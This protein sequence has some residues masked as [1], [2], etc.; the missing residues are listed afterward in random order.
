MKT[1]HTVQFALFN[2][3]VAVICAVCASVYANMITV[4]NTND[5]GP[6]SLRQALVDA[7]GV[8]TITFA[9]TGTIGLTS[10]EL[11]IDK[12]LT[13]SGPGP[14]LLAVS[15]ASKT[16]F[17]IFH[18]TAI[19]TVNIEGLTI[20]GGDVFDYGGGILNDQ[21]TLIL[22]NC[23]VVDNAAYSGG[24]GI[25]NDDG[26]S[27]TIVNSIISGNRAAGGKYPYGGGV[28]GGS[29]TITN[30]TISGNSAVGGGPPCCIGA[31]GGIAG[32][33]TMTNSTITGNYA[34]LDGGGISGGGTI[35][36][37]TISNN[38]A[39]G[40]TNNL[41][42]T[43]GGISGGGS[44]SNC[45]ISGN[46]VFGS[47]YKGAGLGGGIYAS[48]G[49][50]T[51][52]NSTFSGNYIIEYG[53]GGGIYN[54][55]TLEIGNTILNRTGFGENIFNNGGT[56]TSA[57]YN[58]SNDDGGG[59]L[60]GP[61]DLINTDPLL[62]PL[63]DNGGPTQTHALLPSSSAVDAGDPSFAPPPWYDQ[64]G[65]NFYRL[66]ND[67]IDIGSFEVQ[68]G[69]AVTPT[70]TPTATPTPTPS[71]PAPTPRTRPTPPPRP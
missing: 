48:F 9:V 43:G 24:G 3:C 63:Q 62:G 44:I 58:L 61:G 51:I 64:R 1:K 21:A 32:G 4:T 14:D 34:G 49:T 35:T 69:P 54:R 13:L 38:G 50:V 56:I 47:V 57:G 68:E 27:L 39:G 10:A 17:R 45:T 65:P 19:R 28:A 31:G 11:V 37:C 20:S 16:Q 42:G 41:P 55:A 33:G 71:R 22:T 70:P 18:V 12:N 53:N 60:N 2:L 26:G 52:S 30:S 46:S 23:S 5:S 8:D 67:R 7:N 15:R 6:G 36:N 66:R 25:Y 40:G 59:Y 29:L